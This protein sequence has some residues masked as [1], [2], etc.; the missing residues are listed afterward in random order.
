[1]AGGAQIL[2]SIVVFL[3]HDEWQDTIFG[4]DR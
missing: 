4:R 1:M 2:G 3:C